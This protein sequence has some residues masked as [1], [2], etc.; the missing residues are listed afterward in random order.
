[1][2]PHNSETDDDE[3]PL[4]CFVPTPELPNLKHLIYFIRPHNWVNVKTKMRLCF[5]NNCTTPWWIQA[6][7]K[8][9]YVICKM[10]CKG[11]TVSF[12][13]GGEGSTSSVGQDKNPL[14]KLEI[15]HWMVLCWHTGG[16]KVYWLFCHHSQRVN[17]I[18]SSHLCLLKITSY[19]STCSLNI[20]PT[21]SASESKGHS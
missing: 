10:H 11:I 18:M 15:L 1:M 7:M 2:C 14:N 20:C 19:F 16:R 4:T 5:N 9:S 12:Y 3:S 13:F 6:M 8:I 17:L 21:I